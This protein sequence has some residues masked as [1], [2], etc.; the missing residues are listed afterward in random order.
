MPR[1]RESGLRAE[2]RRCQ[3]LSPSRRCRTP[4][5]TAG[6][7]C[8]GPGLAPAALAVAAG[9]GTPPGPAA[10]DG[11][12]GQMPTG[13]SGGGLGPGAGDPGPAAWQLRLGDS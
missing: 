4:A 7:G 3:L 12:P 9:P 5:T 6:H 1:A 8:P 11:G 13:R 2:S 10:R